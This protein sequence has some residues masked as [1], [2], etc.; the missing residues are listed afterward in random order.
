[1]RTE[2]DHGGSDAIRL[3][4]DGDAVQVRRDSASDARANLAAMVIN[5]HGGMAAVKGSK[6][7]QREA[8]ARWVEL[9]EYLGLASSPP[10]EVGTCARH[11]C[12][13]DLS[14]TGAASS[15][16]GGLTFTARKK[17]FCSQRCMKLANPKNTEA[18]P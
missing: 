4:T 9:L 16:G 6:R 10:R 7:L 2:F 15:T 3:S 1:M 17:G 8:A 14:L 12:G 5:M 13:K 11:G 18:T